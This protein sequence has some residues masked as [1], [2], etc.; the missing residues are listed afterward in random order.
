MAGRHGDRVVRTIC[1]ECRNGCGMYVHVEDGRAVRVEAAPDSRGASQRFCSRARA[2]LERLYSPSRLLY[3]Q[4]RIGEKGDGIW[5]RISWDEALD[6][7]A[8]K[9]TEAKER[10]GAESVCLAKG[11]Y[12][13]AADSVSRLGN[14]FGTPNV[15][16]IDN[17][18]YVPSATGRLMTY[19]FDGMP[20]VAGGPAC[21]LLWGNSPN[22]PL[23]DGAKLIVVNSLRTEAA[24]RSDIWLRP[25][26]G[27]DLALALAM[28]NVIVEEELYDR[29]FVTEWTLGFDALARHLSD[30]SPTKVAEITWVPAEDIVAAARLFATQHPA[31]L[32]NGNASEDT[33]NSTQTAR[34]FAIMQALCGSLDVPGGTVHA[35]GTILYEGTDRDI[36][37]HLLPP[38]QDAKKLG[39]K[40]GFF[41][42]HDLWDPIVWKPVEVRPHYVLN[43]I[44]EKEPYP[45]NV[46]GVFG[47]NPMLT[48]SDSRRVFEALKKVDFLVVADLIMTPTAALADLVLPVTSYLET[49]AVLVKMGGG[50]CHLEPQQEVVKVGECRSDI[51][52]ISQI[53]GRLGLGRVLRRGSAVFSR[54]IPGADGHDVRRT[55]APARDHLVR[56]QIQEIPRDRLRDPI[57]EGGAL[58]QS[59]REMGLRA[60]PRISRAGGDA[61]QRAGDA[62]RVPPGADQL[63]RGELRS[64]PGP[65]SA[66][67]PLEKARCDRD[68]PSGY[69]SRPGHHGGG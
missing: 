55:Q 65:P 53:A 35:E 4:K 9:F 30:Y 62:E 29:P 21:L 46:L 3:P 14:V 33:Y 68:H 38:E 49:D 34:A 40:A 18:C 60:A 39:A 51:E 37:R 22:P 66:G 16:S 12:G 24:K 52:I 57:R 61:V 32:W 23:R 1:Q 8:S 26:P 56:S 58:L 7:V 64:F 13:R 15:T 25:R 43:A 41:P 50:V 54:W 44:L 28:L 36:L 63:S 31:C 20:D 67:D 5:R 47:S 10:N 19:G 6:A 59:L 42:S 45:V 27:S 17:T 2:G 11:M 48:W 69:R